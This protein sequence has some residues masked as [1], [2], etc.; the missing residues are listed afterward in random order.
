MRFILVRHGQTEWNLEHRVQ[1]RTDL[2]LNAQGIRQAEL[3]AGALRNI[4][5]DIIYCS[6]L[7]RAK[8]TAEVLLREMNRIRL[9]AG[10]PVLPEIIPLPE[11]K[12]VAFGNWE[13]KTLEEIQVLYPEDYHRW[14]QNPAWEI[15]TG[16][17]SRESLRQRTER[18]FEIIRENTGLSGDSSVVIVAHG[19]ILVYI[20]AWLLRSDA[21]RREIIVENASITTVDYDF[22]TGIGTLI[23]MNETDHL[24]GGNKTPWKADLRK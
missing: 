3:V 7:T 2:P 16:G 8:E 10:K 21:E 14:V 15:P 13:G 9:S 18:A 11:L 23:R 17:E 22:N 12:E 20:I 1:G 4:P 19:A 6:S 24:K 5:A